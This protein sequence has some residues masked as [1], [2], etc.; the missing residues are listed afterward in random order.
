MTMLQILSI[1]A[2]LVMLVAA[3]GLRRYYKSEISI[4]D[5]SGGVGNT[6]FFLIRPLYRLLSVGAVVMFVQIFFVKEEE[7]W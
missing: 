5:D 2:S 6:R 7:K 1:I 4:G 3:Y